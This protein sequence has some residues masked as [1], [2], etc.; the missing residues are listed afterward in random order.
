M[1]EELTEHE[2]QYIRRWEAAQILNMHPETL[3]RLL[4]KGRYTEIRTARFGRETRYN[5]LDVFRVAFPTANGDFLAQL[6]YNH[7]MSQWKYP[8]GT[9]KGGRRNVSKKAEKEGYT[10]NAGNVD[11]GKLGH[12]RIRDGRT[13]QAQRLRGQVSD[14]Q[15]A[16]RRRKAGIPGGDVPRGSSFAGKLLDLSATN[17][18]KR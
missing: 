4:K 12:L 7:R 6:M 5:A 18:R 13:D 8:N 15:A 14:L 3:P 2:Q 10:E 11:N 9:R 16:I 1:G 17:S